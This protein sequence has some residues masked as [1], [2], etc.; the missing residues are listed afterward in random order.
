MSWPSGT[1]ALVTGGNSG[2]GRVIALALARAGAHVVIVARNEE[3]GE[4]VVR[5]IAAAG[6]TAEFHTVDIGQEAQ[7]IALR[8][9]LAQ[10]LPVL[11]L[12]VNNAGVGLRRSGVTRDMGPGARWQA[13]RGTNLDGTYLMTAHFLPRLARSAHGA[14]VNISST[15]SLHGNWGL[16][17]AA[18]AGVEGMTRAFAAEAAPHGVRV[19]S[20]SPGWIATENDVSVHPSGTA[21]GTWDLPPSLLGRMGRPEEIAAAVMFLGSPEAS[22]ITGQTLIVDGG[23]TATD[24][25]SLTLLTER[26]DRI[27]SRPERSPR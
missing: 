14:V 10:R 22:F 6:G 26:G 4:A 18:K 20:V 12:L 17:C 24:Y 3:R 27:R 16:Y 7:V 13:I 5:K 19:N 15:A 21:D 23:L 1:A 8:D 25:T 11:D 2:I 9:C